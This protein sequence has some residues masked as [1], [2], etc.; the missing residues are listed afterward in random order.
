MTADESSQSLAEGERS[1]T[2]RFSF[3]VPVMGRKMSIGMKIGDN[4]YLET[5]FAVIYGSTRL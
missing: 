1:A 3:N 5:V 4:A 2:A